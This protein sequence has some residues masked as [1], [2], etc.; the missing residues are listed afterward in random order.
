MEQTT[1]L[2]I[3]VA[4]TLENGIGNNGGLPWRLPSDMS[5]FQNITKNFSKVDNNDNIVVMGRKTWDSIPLKFKPLSGR[6]NVVLSRDLDFS[7]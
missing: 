4:A 7:R 1:T 2:S 6:I 5:Y 3:I